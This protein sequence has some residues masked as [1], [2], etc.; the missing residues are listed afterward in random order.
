M[1][2]RG[3]GNAHGGHLRPIR[4][5]NRLRRIGGP[6][7]FDAADN[8]I[9]VKSFLAVALREDALDARKRMIRQKLQYSDVLPGAGALPVTLLQSSADFSK[10]RW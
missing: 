7:P 9:G 5:I 1:P 8:P 2:Q 3:R 10:N 4:Q 6:H